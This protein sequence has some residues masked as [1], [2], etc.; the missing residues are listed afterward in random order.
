MIPGRLLVT[1]ASAVVGAT[2]RR[3]T[4]AGRSWTGGGRSARR[5]GDVQAVLGLERCLVQRDP[6]VD[7]GPQHRVVRGHGLRE[8]VTDVRLGDEPR[9][10]SGSAQALEQVG[11]L[12]PD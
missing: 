8:A 4:R 7:P 10:P 11:V 6:L 3:L 9:G 5:A 1:P 12:V 2:A